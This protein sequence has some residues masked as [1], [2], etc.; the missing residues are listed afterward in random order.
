MLRS[1]IGAKGSDRGLAPDRGSDD[2][3]APGRH[4]RH[5]LACDVIGA[6]HIHLNDATEPRLGLRAWGIDR[7]HAL[8]ACI[9][10]EHIQPIDSREAARHRGAIRYVAEERAYGA[11]TRHFAECVRGLVYLWIVGENSEV[12]AGAGE[13]A[14][15]AETDATTSAGY[16]HPLTG[17][18]PI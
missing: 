15:H 6:E 7:R 4:P 12:G 16:Q 8:D 11:A 3:S 1:A 10:N 18:V 17:K 13:A 14:G 5:R 9:G 2:N